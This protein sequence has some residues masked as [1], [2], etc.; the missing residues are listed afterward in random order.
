MKRLLLSLL[1]P[2]P[3][4]LPR[5]QGMSLSLLPLLQTLMQ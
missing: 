1:R 4:L 2:L 5:H 3:L